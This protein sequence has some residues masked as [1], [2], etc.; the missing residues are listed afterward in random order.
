MSL[1]QVYIT[2][3]NA[4]KVA[5]LKETEISILENDESS[6]WG[7]GTL[8]N[9]NELKSLAGLKSFLID[10][11]QFC[12]NLQQRNHANVN[13]QLPPAFHITSDCE[14]LLSDYVSVNEPLN[15]PENI[16]GE[17]QEWKN[18]LSRAQ[19]LNR[20]WIK[21]RI[22]DKW[23][24]EPGIPV[25]LKI[26]NSGVQMRELKMDL[27]DLLDGEILNKRL[28]ELKSKSLLNMKI[29]EWFE[30]LSPEN[31]VG[32]QR[33]D[34]IEENEL[35]ENGE[36]NQ[37]LDRLKKEVVLPLLKVMAYNIQ[38]KY[39]SGLQAPREAIEG[40]GFL[41]CGKCYGNKHV[42]IDEVINLFNAGS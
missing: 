8:L 21:D 9:V 11:M 32:A 29:I 2:N 13:W 36:F 31:K 39:N 35:V 41:P 38:I 18:S 1:E 27:A 23:N 6:F 7:L 5:S 34:F 33:T 37:V 40:L 10:P 14:Y 28:S 20:A 26:P 12:N 24:L 22:R 17:F 15:L 25:T 16:R 3:A 4:K 42:D 19:L 30:N